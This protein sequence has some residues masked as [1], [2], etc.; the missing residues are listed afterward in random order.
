MTSE[1]KYGCLSTSFSDDYIYILLS[2]KTKK[3][4]GNLSKTVADL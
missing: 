3:E 2:G 1:N 4:N